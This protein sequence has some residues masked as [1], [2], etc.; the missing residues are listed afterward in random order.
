MWEWECLWKV[1]VC[2]LECMCVRN[3]EYVCEKTV[4]VFCE[5]VR[6]SLSTCVM[7]AWV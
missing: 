3:S 2:M 5:C 7:R 6:E 4:W 1:E